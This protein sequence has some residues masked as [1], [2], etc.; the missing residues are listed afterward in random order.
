LCGAPKRTFCNGA[1]YEDLSVQ[2]PP[3]ARPL[4]PHF[5]SGP[6]A[7]RPG[8]NPRILRDACVAR[9]HRSPR[10]YAKLADAIERTRGLLEIPDEHR[11]AIVPGSNTGAFELA[12]WSLLGARGVDILAWESFGYGWASDVVDELRLQDVRVF[13]APYGKLPELA[14]VDMDRDVVLVWNGTTSG[15][16]VPDASWIKEDRQGLAL[17][18]ATS[19]VFAMDIPWNKLDV[20]TFSWQKALGGEGQHGMLVLSSR[21][22]KRL[23]TYRPPWPI[24]KVFRIT[25]RGS[26]DESIFR[27]STINTP[28]MLCV[29]DYLDALDWAEQAG[30]LPGLIGRTQSNFAVLQRW[31]EKTPWVAFL[32]QDP[33]ARSTTSVCLKLID[34][35]FEDLEP[36]MRRGFIADMCSVLEQENVAY[37]IQSYRE[38]PPG[39]RIWCGC[40]VE[41]RD[42]EALTAWLDYAFQRIKSAKSG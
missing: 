2:T 28:S 5:S 32:A 14:R 27:G 11:L 23:E 37:D 10:A 9:N 33:A 3:S 8:W 39:L 7:K 15:V 29:E 13:E 19:A 24:P 40:T 26:L 1:F 36:E 20:V 35:W 38:A 22:V 30:G 16:C 17:C 21:A 6:C 4:C 41:A 25:K 42:L 34:P 18:D 12:L 31:V